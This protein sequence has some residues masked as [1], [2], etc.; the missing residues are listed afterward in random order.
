MAAT[1]SRTDTKGTKSS[2]LPA[3]RAGRATHLGSHKLCGR[4]TTSTFL[5]VVFEHTVLGACHLG[6]KSLSELCRELHL[7]LLLPGPGLLRSL[8]GALWC[9]L[10]AKIIETVRRSCLKNCLS[11]RCRLRTAAPGT[12]STSI[13]E[14][15][16]CVVVVVVVVR[17]LVGWLCVVRCCW[18]WCCGAVV[19]V[20]VLL[21]CCCGGVERFF[22]GFEIAACHFFR[23][24]V[25]GAQFPRF[26]PQGDVFKSSW[27]RQCICTGFSLTADST[28]TACGFVISTMS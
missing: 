1:T 3:C 21:W 20:V 18:L 23:K 15:M 22:H 25:S 4:R 12:L 2:R 10:S 11:H 6:E 28:C 27:S 14:S 24:S 8:R 26:H 9:V 7:A 16:C 17:W 13:V 5:R 19:G